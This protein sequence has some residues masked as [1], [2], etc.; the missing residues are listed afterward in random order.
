MIYK[1]V[2]YEHVIQEENSNAIP[3]R[4]IRQDHG[5][6]KT[7]VKKQEAN[8]RY[9]QNPGSHSTYYAVD[10]ELSRLDVEWGLSAASTALSSSSS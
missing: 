3:N 4:C 6:K 10:K 5:N 2:R 9:A 8:E 1:T 7:R